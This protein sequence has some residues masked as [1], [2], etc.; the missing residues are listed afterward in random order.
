[1]KVA[2]IISSLARNVATEASVTTLATDSGRDGQE[3]A[4]NT[5]DDYLDILTRLMIVEDQ[6]A[7]PTHLRSAATARKSPKRHFVDPSLAAAAL[8]ATPTSILA[9]LNFFGLLF[10]SLAVRD[11]R[12]YAQAVD[13]VVSQY[14]DSSGLE[15][16]AIV[17]TGD[18]RWGAFEVKLGVG[19]VDAAA[20][21]L[22]RFRD[23]VDTRRM[24]E[25][26]FLGVITPSGLGYRRPDGVHVLP[27][28]AL[29]P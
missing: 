21:G 7:W 4:R 22:L 19:Q 17:T 9:D 5:V 26:A 6:P 13:G 23:R 27:L 8:R 29:A 3:L 16:D 28:G 2:R 11:L 15:V 12:I 24:G 10:E 1:M 18:G 25:P 14:R 20:R